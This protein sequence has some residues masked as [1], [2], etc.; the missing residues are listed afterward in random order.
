MAKRLVDIDDDLL[1]RA[2]SIAGT[3]TIKDTVNTAL[4]RLVDDDKAVQHVE[5][6]RRR[7]ALDLGKIEEARRPRTAR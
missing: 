4:R 1:G 5:R 7:G 3:E 6:L 2:R